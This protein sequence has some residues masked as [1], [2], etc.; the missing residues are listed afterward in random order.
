VTFTPKV[1]LVTKGSLI[2][3]NNNENVNLNCA[4]WKGA[5]LDTFVV[6]GLDKAPLDYIVKSIAALG[7]NCVRLPYS[8]ELYLGNPSI[9]D[10]KVAANTHLKGLKALEVFDQT[11]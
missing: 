2:L 11:V 5:Q 3:D 6:S 4:N 10:T 7:F 9:D 8:V 1:P